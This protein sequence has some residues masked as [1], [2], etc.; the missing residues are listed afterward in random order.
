MHFTSTTALVVEVASFLYAT[1]NYIP[2]CATKIIL[3]N[4]S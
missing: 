2:L 1:P 3:K 4:N